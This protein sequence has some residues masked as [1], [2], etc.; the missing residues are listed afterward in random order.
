MNDYKEIIGK[1]LYN[2]RKKKKYPVKYVTDRLG[3]ARSTYNNYEAGNRAPNGEKLVQ[4]AEIL[5]T[6]VDFITGKTK[7]E[8]QP[9]IEI[10]KL[11]NYKYTN[12]GKEISPEQ[13]AALAQV[14]QS[15]LKR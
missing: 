11:A 3:I 7:D 14:I 5:G 9:T 2:L 13:A 1:N 6:T 4:L 12:N 8:S 15:L 10:S